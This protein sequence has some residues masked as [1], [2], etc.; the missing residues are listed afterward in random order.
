MAAKPIRQQCTRSIA[1]GFVAMGSPSRK[2]VAFRQAQQQ[3][4]QQQANALHET[5]ER[6]R[7]RR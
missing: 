3:Q 1:N 2:A 5:I 7:R 4:Q 6:R